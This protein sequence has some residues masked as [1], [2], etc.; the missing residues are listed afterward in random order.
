MDITIQLLDYSVEEELFKFEVENRSY[1]ERI[2]LSRDDRYYDY[3]NFKQIL[4]DLIGEQQKDLIYMYLIK[5]HYQ[6]IIGRVNLSSIMR[7]PFNKAEL[8]YRTGEKHQGNGYTTKAV[9]LVL[10]EAANRHK[11]H[12]MEAG[13]SPDNIGS[14]IVLI[15]NGFQFVGKH[16]KY[17]HNNGK[18]NDS[19]IF[20]KI[21][22]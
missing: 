10:D 13:T 18:W 20:E 8:G 6:D 22:D 12:R 17:I 9:Q 3:N 11:L 2:G 21:L 4:K 14:Q 7:G 19:I 16:S 15:K 5:D 1:F